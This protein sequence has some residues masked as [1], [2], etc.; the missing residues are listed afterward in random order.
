MFK[1]Q[2]SPFLHKQKI[3]RYLRK[4]VHSLTL[5]IELKAIL[6]AEITV[7]EHSSHTISSILTSH[8]RDAKD[9]RPHAQPTCQCL[10]LTRLSQSSPQLVM[11][12]LG[13]CAIKATHLPDDFSMIKQNVKNPLVSS[14]QQALT[15]LKTKLDEF[16]PSL[17]HFHTP[18]ST[19]SA[20][21]HNTLEHRS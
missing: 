16:L 13:H 20:F 9:F 8:I 15:T 5:P 11:D 1:I 19:D 10:K 2:F 18:L 14:P 12:R 4:M 3:K 17:F 7:V 21:V 6:C